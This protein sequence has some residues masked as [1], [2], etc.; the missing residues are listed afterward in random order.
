M[1]QTPMKTIRLPEG[2]YPVDALG[3]EG[4]E[5]LQ[6]YVFATTQLHH[7]RNMQAILNKARNAYIADLKHEI[8]RERIG[9][10]FSDLL[11]DD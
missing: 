2:D 1:A 10:D 6:D 9:L 4:Q 8:L 3:S 7:L 11:D 5:V